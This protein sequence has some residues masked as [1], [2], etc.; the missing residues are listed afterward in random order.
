[1]RKAIPY[2]IGAMLVAA[3]ILLF[4]SKEKKERTFDKRLSMSRTDKIPYGAW[5]AYEHLK[6]EFPDARI[7]VNR[8]EP[9]LWDSIT[10]YESKQLLFI[11]SPQ[12]QATEFDMNRLITF[13]ENGNDVF[14][15]AR[16][17][18]GSAEKLLDC[19]TNIYTEYSDNY[20]KRDTL[21]IRLVHGML[22]DR[23]PFTYPGA[24]FDAFFYSSNSTYSEVMGT[25]GDGR[26]NFIRMQAGKGHIYLH[27]APLAFSNYFLLN[28]DNMRYY[29]KLMSLFDPSMKKV[30]WDEYFL[31]KKAEDNEDSGNQKWL[32]VLFKHPALRAAL[33]TAMLALLV[34][35]LLEMRRKQ[36][37][38]PHMAPP[39]NDSLDFVK[40]IGRLYY[41]KGDH[42]NLCRKM[43]SY[44]LEHVRNR[45]KLPTTNLDESF[46]Q[47]LQYK[48]GAPE[49]EIR[50]IV[51]FIKYV[52]DSPAVT[53]DELAHFH[54]Q[55]ESFYQKA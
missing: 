1:M 13:A 42:R 46:M 45:Y 36:R 32:S 18:S 2:I 30:V 50:G 22:N 47:L 20:E 12:F 29:E 52:E 10:S 55:L 34:F 15:S 3:L 4:S 21:N 40:T 31:N 43:G 27:L 17:I 24:R 48:S 26:T 54:A 53:A 8:K 5:V 44:F 28:G 51:T 23:R 49:Q 33:L 7:S 16:H 37:I 41:D 25:E 6:D 14:I 19:N 39:R 35:T 38:I 9:G 11:V